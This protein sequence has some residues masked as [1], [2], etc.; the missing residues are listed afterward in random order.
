MFKHVLYD[1]SG[2][3]GSVDVSREG[4]VTWET[5]WGI[6]GDSDRGPKTISASLD[7]YVGEPDVMVRWRYKGSWDWYWQ[8]DDV[9]VIAYGTCEPQSVELVYGV[10]SDAN[11]SQPLNGA[12]RE[13]DGKIGR[14][15]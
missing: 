1:F 14:A 7:D 10:V 8:V 2:S 3:S 11:D 6:D 5:V 4:G 12:T 9:E 13:V 15:S